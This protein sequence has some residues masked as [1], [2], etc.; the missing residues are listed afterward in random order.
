MF[1]TARCSHCKDQKSKFG[2]AFA[3]VDYIDC[4]VQ[5]DLC[6]NAGIQGYPTWVDGQGKQYPGNQPLEQLATLSTCQLTQ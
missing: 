5:K 6:T 3:K 2:D 1:G 4:D